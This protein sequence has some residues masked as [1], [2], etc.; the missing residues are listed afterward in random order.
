M[1]GW[2]TMIKSIVF[3]DSTLLADIT[4]SPDIF[5]MGPRPWGE[6]YDQ[7][8]ELVQGAI[9][10]AIDGDSYTGSRCLSLMREYHNLLSGLQRCRST[11]VND[12]NN[13]FVRPFAD[14]LNQI[15]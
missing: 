15:I 10:R 4:Q 2:F 6:L 12:A 1:K 3:A 5:G 11:W 8:V 14:V 7:R 13:G 9:T